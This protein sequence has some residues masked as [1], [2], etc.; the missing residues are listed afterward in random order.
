MRAEVASNMTRE[1]N[2]RIKSKNKDAVMEALIEANK[3]DVPS[4][5][6]DS[7]AQT[8]AQQMQQ[9][10]EAQGAGGQVPIAPDMFKEQAERR[11][12]LGLIMSEMVK[13]HDIKVDNDKVKT[14]VEEIAQPYE[15]PDEVVKWYYSD[16]RRLSEVE[17]MVFED[18][19][20]EM[21]MSEAK[22]KENQVAFKD[23]V[24]PQPAA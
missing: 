11:V 10:L 15:H 24:S 4:A 3:V 1:M 19:I 5:L 13:E 16:K 2:Q 6:I 22:I 17:S 7:E 23:L 18:M 14:M 9:N 21:V 12:I 8:L 20:V